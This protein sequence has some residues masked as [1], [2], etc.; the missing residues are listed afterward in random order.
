MV[1]DGDAECVQVAEASARQVGRGAGQGSG[2]E[3]PTAALSRW[4]RARQAGC[5]PGRVL[6]SGDVWRLR[7]RYPMRFR[8][9]S[10]NSVKVPRAHVL[11]SGGDLLGDTV[12]QLL[13]AQE[14]R[15][16]PRGA[17]GN[18]SGGSVRGP[19]QWLHSLCLERVD[20]IGRLGSSPYRFVR[21]GD[22]LCGEVALSDF[23][24]TAQAFF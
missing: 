8:A 16:P 5:L 10:L 20:A 9:A 15:P 12:D 17:D 1:K 23:R 22:F 13:Q 2:H 11:L 18:V 3:S 19:F 14:P 21:L 6:L 4:S 24:G 7:Q